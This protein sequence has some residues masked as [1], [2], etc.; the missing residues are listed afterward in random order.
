MQLTGRFMSSAGEKSLG[1]LDFK[2]LFLEKG[3]RDRKIRNEGVG[4]AVGEWRYTH[5]EGADYLSLDYSTLS[6]LM[7]EREKSTNKT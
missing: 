4:K 3:I 1:R 6:R 5:R 2:D 7:K